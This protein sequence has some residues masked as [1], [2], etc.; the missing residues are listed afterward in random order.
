MSD[1]SEGKRETRK[2]VIERET[3][4]KGS[5]KLFQDVLSI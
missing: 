2:E 3:E 5:Y 4:N 1:Q